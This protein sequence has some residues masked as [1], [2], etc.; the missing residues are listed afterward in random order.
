MVKAQGYALLNSLMP[1]GDEM[2]YLL[3]QTQ[4]A[5]LSTNPLIPG[6]NCNVIHT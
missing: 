3:K 2:S 6:V 1:G 4:E 5:N